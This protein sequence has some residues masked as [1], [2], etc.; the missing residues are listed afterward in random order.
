MNRISPARTPIALYSW[1]TTN[2]RRVH[3]MLEELGWPY[4]AHAVN[5]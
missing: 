4:D 3:I 2:G 5:L 1:P